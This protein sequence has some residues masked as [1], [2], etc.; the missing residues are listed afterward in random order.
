MDL[1]GGPAAYARAMRNVLPTLSNSSE[2]PDIISDLADSG[3]QGVVNGR[4][5][6]EYSDQES[7]QWEILYDEHVWA[8]RE[9]Q[10]KNAPI[11]ATPCD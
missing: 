4:G 10:N 3:A 7:H 6:Y 2:L 9:I 11:K 5:F 1:T 8:I